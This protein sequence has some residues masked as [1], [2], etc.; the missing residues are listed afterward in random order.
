MRKV[1]GYQAYEGS[2]LYIHGVGLPVSFL[3]DLNMARGV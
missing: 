2:K 1:F 3:D